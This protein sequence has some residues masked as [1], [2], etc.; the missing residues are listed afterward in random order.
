MTDKLTELREA[1]DKAVLT[2]I[3]VYRLIDALL[4]PDTHDEIGQWMGALQDLAD[5]TGLGAGARPY[6]PKKFFEENIAAVR[7][8]RARLKEPQRPTNED[9]MRVW[10]L[11][12]ITASAHSG[13]ASWAWD[14]SFIAFEDWLEAIG[15]LRAGSRA[16]RKETV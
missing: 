14:P 12:F 15:A 8:M 4:E 11:A 9:L 5:A 10:D 6:S 16:M 13:L 1:V 7:E 2:K 3:E